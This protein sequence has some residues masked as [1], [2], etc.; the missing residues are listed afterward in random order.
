MIYSILPIPIRWIITGYDEPPI[1]AHLRIDRDNPQLRFREKLFTQTLSVLQNEEPIQRTGPM[2]KFPTT[3]WI[4]SYFAMKI[5]VLVFCRGLTIKDV[6]LLG[7]PWEINKFAWRH[8][9]QTLNYFYILWPYFVMGSFY[10]LGLLNICIWQ[11][12]LF[13]NLDSNF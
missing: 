3:N 7:L 6:K 11:L 12:S 4:L 2:C 10:L 8:F 1:L 5:S 13:W 9:R